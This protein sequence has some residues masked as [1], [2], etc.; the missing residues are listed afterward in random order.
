MQASARA[1][2]ATP[3]ESFVPNFLIVVVHCL[4]LEHTRECDCVTVQQCL[5]LCNACTTSHPCFTPCFTLSLCSPLLTYPYLKSLC[6]F[7]STF[8]H[9]PSPLALRSYSGAIGPLMRHLL[10]HSG[11][12]PR[13]RSA[14]HTLSLLVSN[15]P[16]R[17]IIASMQGRAALAA[18]LHDCPALDVR[19]QAV[20][21]LWDLDTASG[22]DTAAALQADDL[23]ALLSLLEDTVDA[24]VASHALHL[25]RAAV[26]LPAEER[27]VLPP[28]RAADLAQ[29]LT[30]EMCAHKHHLQDAA[31]YSLGSL[32]GAVLSDPGVPDQDVNA[33]LSALLGALCMRPDSAQCQVLLTVASCLAGMPR[34]RSAMVAGGARHAMLQ[35]S[36]RATD[37][38]LQARALSLVKV[39][40][41]EEGAASHGAN[42]YFGPEE[43]GE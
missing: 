5:S 13:A 11:D 2:Y 6:L 40:N 19:E 22:R 16:N 33:A 18:V 35:F 24:A 31:Q 25:L 8:S 37:S 29:R 17:S 26:D 15:Q 32:L 28:E 10:Q 43:L 41:K 4:H 1:T 14:L 30:R 21:I 34:L 36:R 3:G 23:F 7:F 39:L 27:V 12:E 38:R 42:W 20:Q 9:H